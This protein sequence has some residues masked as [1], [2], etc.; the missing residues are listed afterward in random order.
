[1]SIRPSSIP[2]AVESA[3]TINVRRVASCRVGH[4]TFRSSEKTSL[5]NLKIENPE[6]PEIPGPEV[7]RAGVRAKP[8]PYLFSR[9]TWAQRQ[10]GQN[11]FNSILSGVLRR[12]FSVL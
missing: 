7:L 4:V 12:F 5:K 10:T 11:F 9:K 6:D 8:D 1:M 2:I 3:I